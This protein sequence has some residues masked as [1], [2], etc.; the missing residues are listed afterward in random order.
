LSIYKK[1]GCDTGQGFL[2]GKP[3]PV[4]VA[5]KL[6]AEDADGTTKLRNEGVRPRRIA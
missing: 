5:A 3:Q 1:L 2:F 4:A 6:I